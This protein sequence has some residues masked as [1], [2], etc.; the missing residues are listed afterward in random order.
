MSL[1]TGDTAADE[2]TAL[3]E[4]SYD[5]RERFHMCINRVVTVM[6]CAT[7]GLHLLID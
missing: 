7:H 3:V 2:Y 6:V 4:E 1:L 5:A